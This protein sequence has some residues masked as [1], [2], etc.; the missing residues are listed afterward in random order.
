MAI[1]NC[2][3]CNKRI[4]SVAKSCDYCDTVFN[5]DE[6]D[7]KT[8]R[9]AKSLRFKKLQRLQNFSFIFVL[10]FTIGALALYL[11]ISNSDPLYNTVGR[12]TL[13]IGFVGYIATRAMLIYIRRT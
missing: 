2:P 9:K 1:I 7:E 5:D 12:V 6:V 13:S 11:G 4:S 8:Y 10:L 3:A